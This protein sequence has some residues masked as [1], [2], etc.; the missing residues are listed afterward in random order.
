[1]I[2]H[3][4][5][6]E[7]DIALAYNNPYFTAPRAGRLMR[8]SLDWLP[9]LWANEGDLILVHESKDNQGNTIPNI[10]HLPKCQFVTHKQ[11][12]RWK[13]DISRVE[14]WGWDSAIKHELEKINIPCNLLPTDEQLTHIRLL[15]HRRYAM[16]ALEE[17][18]T[19]NS[20]KSTARTTNLIGEA[21]EIDSLLE[22]SSYTQNLNQFVIKSPWSSSG[23][24]VRIVSHGL[25]SALQKWTRGVIQQQG[26]IMIE[27]LYDKIIDFG[28]EFVSNENDVTFAGLS[29]FKTLKGTYEG[30][31]LKSELQKESFLAHWISIDFLH[32]II[33]RLCLI[34]KRDVTPWYKGYIGVDMMIINTGKQ[35]AL[36][37][38]VEIN[39][40][41]TMGHVAIALFERSKDLY[42]SMRIDYNDGRYKLVL[43]TK[44]HSI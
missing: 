15:S 32:R 16:H 25:D 5:N 23:R 8:V 19:D 11:L 30:N 39:L 27:P 1:M 21:K 14:V 10:P 17:L 33:Q 37:P 12:N 20:F 38:C 42:D 44:A 2:L 41:R 40:R 4:F 26:S 29:I 6:P 35:T 3:V 7:H 18:L 13:N 9:L 36:H 34:L 43:N 22:F 31:L 28:A 24:G